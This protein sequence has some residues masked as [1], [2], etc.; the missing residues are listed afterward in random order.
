MN[1]LGADEE[2]DEAAVAAYGPNLARLRKLKRQYD[3]ENVFHHNLNIL[4]ARAS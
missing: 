2:S 4:P 3:P 1:Y